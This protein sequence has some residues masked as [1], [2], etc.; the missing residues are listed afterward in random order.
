[1]SDLR[2]TLIGPQQAIK[3]RFVPNPVLNAINSLWLINEADDISG[4]ADWVYTTANNLSPARRRTN[5]MLSGLLPSEAGINEQTIWTSYPAWVEDL[6][7]RDPYA[8]RDR[9]I[10]HFHEAAQKHLGDDAP[11][12]TDLLA[13]RTI[14]LD[15]AA[16][17]YTIKE[18]GHSF[19]PD[20]Y[21]AL[22]ALLTDPTALLTQI[23]EHLEYMWSTALAA[24]WEQDQ[25]IIQAAATAYQKL[26]YSGQS[27]AEIHRRVTGREV[28]E[29]WGCTDDAV[30]EVI[31]IPSTHIGP[32][33]MM[34]SCEKD[35]AT[36][37]FGA[38][39]PEGLATDSPGL[40]RTEILMRMSA[41]ADD[42]RLRIL[43]WIATEGEKGAQEIMTHFDLSQSGA[44]RHL[45]QLSA[46]GFI[47][48]RRQEGVK[49]Y[50]I[51]RER[52]DDT[53][54]ALHVYLE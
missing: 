53:L 54:H 9:E 52:I 2:L 51:N 37:V 19:K 8:I 30:Q 5:R 49:R 23:V 3:V 11:P 1:M 35:S 28:P 26:D 39:Q 4:L 14:Y 18:K 50:Q 16:Q 33:L 46:T 24:A 10:A 32:Y 41:L 25:P 38:R 6:K 36:I 21:T 43:K 47:V 40:S 44:S 15:V 34:M 48:E 27:F 13:D 22:H 17:L 12:I 31:F 29:Q 45:R 42:T 7:T 20:A